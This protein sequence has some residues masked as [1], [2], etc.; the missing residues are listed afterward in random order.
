MSNSRQPVSRLEVRFGLVVVAIF[1]ICAGCAVWLRVKHSWGLALEENPSPV[2]ALKQHK[3]EAFE[4]LEP[5]NTPAED[6]TVVAKIEHQPL[7][8][9]HQPSNQTHRLP[10]A[11]RYG[12]ETTSAE[13]IAPVT[14]PPPV[15]TVPPQYL[16]T[17]LEKPLATAFAAIQVQPHDTIWTIAQKHYP[18]VQYAHALWRHNQQSFPKPN[19]LTVGLW[20]EIPSPEYLRE[21]FPETFKSEEVAVAA[22]MTPEPRLRQYKTGP[23]DTLF[24]IAKRQLGATH[25]WVELYRLNHAKVGDDPAVLPVGVM[26]DL[27]D[28]NAKNQ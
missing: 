14:P 27:P 4:R 18:S 12:V 15:Q 1:A 11:N 21:A 20:M 16:P 5:S 22:P 3:V 17:E 25:R 8:E 19:N 9:L 10:A 7:S 23:G 24:S 26:I 6:K 2:A 28:L 13:A